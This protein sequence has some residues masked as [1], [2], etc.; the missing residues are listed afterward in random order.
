MIP[1]PAL[2]LLLATPAWGLDPA[3]D[4]GDAPPSEP[5]DAPETSTDAPQA[6]EDDPL[7]PY[8]ADFDVLME[9]AIG[10]ASQPVAFPWRRTTA[11]LAAHGSY[12]AE[13]N[14]FNSG[15]IGAT[16][17]VP[18]GG[19]LIEVGASWVIVGDSRASRQIAET[20]YRQPGRPDRLEIDLGVSIPLAEG[21]VTAAPKLIPALHLVFHGYVGLR[22]AIHPTGFRG[23]TFGQ[24][25]RATVNPSLTDAEI[26]NLEGARLG[27][28][29][30]DRGRYNVMV[31]IG[32]DI[33]LRQG[34][35]VTPRLSLA[36]PLLAPASNT[37]MLFWGD[38]SLFVGV[39]L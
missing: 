4:T 35:F 17:R 7:S 24:I 5:S 22:Y 15:R 8:R 37:D 20:P 3:A 9:R 34:L 12:L 14:L 27:A 31:G 13:L 39:A 38:V 23:R 11:H 1:R 16:G 6:A 2:L 30:V 25:A 28:M 21:V 10:T 19:T 29:A 18:A 32:N 26:D 33:Y 36:V